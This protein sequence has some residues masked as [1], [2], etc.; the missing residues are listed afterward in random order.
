[1]RTWS[2]IQPSQGIRTGPSIHHDGGSYFRCGRTQRFRMLRIRR[3]GGAMAHFF[4]NFNPFR[5]DVV[6]G[7]TGDRT[8]YIQGFLASPELRFLENKERQKFS[9][10]YPGFFINDWNKPLGDADFKRPSDL[11]L[12][13]NAADMQLYIDH[14]TQ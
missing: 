7:T 3:A 6:Y 14:L 10:R 12:R 9:L 8:E 4:G 13:A 2:I 1:M 11:R 5:G